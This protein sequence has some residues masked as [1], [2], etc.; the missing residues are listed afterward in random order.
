M[1]K[2]TSLATCAALLFFSVSS[3]AQGAVEAAKE[4]KTHAA[5]DPVII[6][7]EMV[8][9]YHRYHGSAAL[10]LGRDAHQ[11]IAKKRF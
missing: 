10:M 5:T 11:K 4:A 1:F 8:A 6:K 2:L 3:R 7:G 9:E